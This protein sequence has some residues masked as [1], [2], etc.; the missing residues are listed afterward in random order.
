MSLTPYNAKGLLGHDFTR[1]EKLRLS[2]AGEKRPMGSVSE[3]I[4]ARPEF[5]GLWPPV[6]SLANSRSQIQG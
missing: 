3:I 5:E 2:I 1:P 4:G 6:D